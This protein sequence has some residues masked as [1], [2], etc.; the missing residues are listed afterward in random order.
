MIYRKLK[1]FFVEKGLN[2][3]SKAAGGSTSLMLATLAKSPRAV[4][5]NWE[6]LY[7]GS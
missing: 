6:T 3:T 2:L 7:R 1:G 5:F 4:S